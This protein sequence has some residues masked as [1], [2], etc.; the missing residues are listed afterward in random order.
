MKTPPIIILFLILSF[1][2]PSL[3]AQDSFIPEPSERVSLKL[4]LSPQSRYRFISNNTQKIEQEIMGTAME[5]NFETTVHYL[6]EVEEDK[7]NNLK[8]K[9]SFERLA[10]I[11]QMPQDT[12]SMD[13][14]Q[15]E[16]E[17]TTPNFNKLA[18]LINQPFYIFLDPQG[19]LSKVEGLPEEITAEDNSA[20]GFQESLNS[21]HFLKEIEKAFYIFPKDSVSM[22]E[23][24]SF[25]QN[26]PLN[27]QIDLTLKKAFTMEGLSEDLAWINIDHH[28]T[29]AATAS[30]LGD[31][32]LNGTQEGTIEVDRAT[33][34]ILFSESNQTL[35]GLIQT[36][37]M[38]IP[39]KI[40]STS[41]LNGEK[42]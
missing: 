26:Q 19:K 18:S 4:N 14:D 39:L 6:F 28:I 21:H 9:A 23:T 35:E 8:I 20:G 30:S 1:A 40:S 31:I 25:T 17:N 13:T 2:S 7:G 27:Q 12:L 10:I 24:W 37:G 34:L 29:S 32:N 16:Q 38:D 5:T 33:G 42:I 11:V 15:T 36:H 22:G 41:T 3:K